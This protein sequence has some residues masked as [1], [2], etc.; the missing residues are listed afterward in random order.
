MGEIDENTLEKLPL[1][2]FVFLMVIFATW[3]ST[4]R[5]EKITALMHT[6]KVLYTQIYCI[7]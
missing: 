1:S 6:V 2:P 4:I 3:I 7:R 5:A